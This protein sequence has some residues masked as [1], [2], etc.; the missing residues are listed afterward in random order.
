MFS[1]FQEH[2][3]QKRTRPKFIFH[4]GSSIYWLDKARTSL[5]RRTWGV[6][7]IISTLSILLPPKRTL[8]LCHPLLLLPPILASIRVFSNESALCMRWPKYW[9]FS[10]SIIPSKEIPGLISFRMA[11]LTRWTWAWLNSGNWWWTGRPGVLQFMGSQRVGHYWAIELNWTE[12]NTLPFLVPNPYTSL[13]FKGVFYCVWCL[14]RLLF[15][16]KIENVVLSHT[17]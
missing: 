12:E 5:L 6:G 10:F 2:L 4:L 17:F 8:I 15:N 16:L 3:G 7:G 13:S 14:Q 11:S 1:N 9:S